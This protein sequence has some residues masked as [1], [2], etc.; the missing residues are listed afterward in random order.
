MPGLEDV[1]VPEPDAV[2]RRLAE[3]GLPLP[4]LQAAAREGQLAGDFVDDSQPRFA[5]GSR[6]YCETNGTLRFQ[7]INL[8]Q[9]WTKLDPAGIPIIVSPDGTVCVTAMAGNE[10]TGL[11]GNA[12][13][14]TRNP[15]GDA[16]QRIIRR[17]SQLELSEELL[18]P[19][20][21][22]E[23]SADFVIDAPTWFFLYHRVGRTSKVR[24]ELSLATGVSESG[25]LIEWSER[26]ILPEIDLLDQPPETGGRTGPSPDVVVPVERRA[27]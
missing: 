2:L 17:N 1:E 21:R 7:L 9:P 10:N 18:P 5:R 4:V 19:E 11:R 26:L 16:G 22:H 24:M 15:R 6:I 3:L 13:A 23:A 14:Q 27:S 12:H 20:I 8:P 25:K